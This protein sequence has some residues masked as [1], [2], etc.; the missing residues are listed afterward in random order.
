VR[1]S[2]ALAIVEAAAAAEEAP[3]LGAVE[4]LLSFA[5]RPPDGLAEAYGKLG[6]EDAEGPL[7]ANVGATVANALASFEERL[8]V[9]AR[10][11][12]AIAAH[13]AV[14]ATTDAFYD[15]ASLLKLTQP[16]D[17][18]EAEHDDLR[19]LRVRAL[20]AICAMKDELWKWVNFREVL[21]GFGLPTAFTAEEGR[22]KLR[23]LAASDA[24]YAVPDDDDVDD[25]DTD[26]E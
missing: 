9:A 22:A 13:L 14:E 20:E 1:F 18:E 19:A 10:L 15:V 7:G 3:P 17:A 6:G 8:S 26:D 2:L 21:G 24:P 16:R 12:P 25:T 4:L 11:V 23:E 5:E